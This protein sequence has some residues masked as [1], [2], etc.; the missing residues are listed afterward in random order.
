METLLTGALNMIGSGTSILAHVYRDGRRDA[1]EQSEEARGWEEI[2]EGL[3]RGGD[4]ELVAEAIPALLQHGLSALPWRLQQRIAEYESDPRV[5]R[6]RAEEAA[7]ITRLRR[8][9]KKKPATTVN[10]SRLV[11]AVK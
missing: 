1:T 6:R 2:Q 8:R 7:G 4:A 10:G 5:K 11:V 3:S 9:A